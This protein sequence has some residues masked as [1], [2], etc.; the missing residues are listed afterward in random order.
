MRA[1]LSSTSTL[2]TAKP[3][4][5]TPTITLFTLSASS[6]VRFPGADFLGGRSVTETFASHCGM[7]TMHPAGITPETAYRVNGVVRVTDFDWRL[8]STKRVR[9][10]V[11][12]HNRH[13]SSPTIHHR[14]AARHWERQADKLETENE[15]ETALAWPVAVAAYEERAADEATT[16]RAV[17]TLE[18]IGSEASALTADAGAL[19][20]AE[21]PTPDA[22]DDA[23]TP[24]EVST[25]ELA[26]TE[27][28]VTRCRWNCCHLTMRSSRNR[29]R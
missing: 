3:L 17:P 21:V 6:H 10:R 7:H 26:G 11:E 20:D 4:K 9:V 5:L 13:A 2:S 8:T 27:G 22:A 16:E 14:Y 15:L 24:D 25:G 1:L 18:T 12:Q 23:D 29:Q 28:T 19:D